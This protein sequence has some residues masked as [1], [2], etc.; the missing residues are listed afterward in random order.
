MNAYD[1]AKMHEVLT[2]SE[3]TIRVAIPEEADT[4][5]PNTCSIREKAQD[6]VFSLLVTW[7]KTENG[8][9]LIF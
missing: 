4:L 9:N 8:T 3:D 7:K 5:L 6:K 2:E 1:S